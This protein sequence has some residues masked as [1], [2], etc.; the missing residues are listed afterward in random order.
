MTQRQQYLLLSA[1]FVVAAWAGAITLGQWAVSL[2][3]NIV[4]A[5]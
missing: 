2:A 3:L 5:K 1:A 4:G